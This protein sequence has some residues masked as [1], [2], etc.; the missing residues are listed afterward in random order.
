MC[1]VR[2][3][4]IERVEQGVLVVSIDRLTGLLRSALSGWAGLPP[5]SLADPADAPAEG[6]VSDER[7]DELATQS[8]SCDR[9]GQHLSGG[10]GDRNP[11]ER[12]VRYLVSVSPPVALAIDVF[13]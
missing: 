12:S 3:R 1:L 10:G 8:R 11:P 4:G 9:P 5:P 2:A 13:A 7:A 6:S